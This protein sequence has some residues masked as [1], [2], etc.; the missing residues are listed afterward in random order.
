MHVTES[1]LTQD[2]YDGDAVAGQHFMDSPITREAVV[3]GSLAQRFDPIAYPQVGVTYAGTDSDDG[4][5]PAAA[6]SAEF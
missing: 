5:V 3:D 1:T 2:T 4:D 6:T